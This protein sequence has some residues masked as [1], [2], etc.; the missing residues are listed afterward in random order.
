VRPFDPVR[1]VDGLVPGGAVGGNLGGMSATGLMPTTPVNPEAVATGRTSAPGPTT[2]RIWQELARASFAVLSHVTPRGEPRC[3]GVVYAIA[4]RRMFVAVAHDGWKARHIAA[5]GRVAVTVPVRRGGIMSL[6]VPIPPATI[7][8][9]G[10]AVVH[11]TGSPG[12]E[13][14]M[15]ALAH[16][17]PPERRRTSRI[18]EIRPEGWFLT[19]GVAVSLTRMRNPALARAHVP[20]G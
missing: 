20:V 19:Y 18:I 14:A 4:D 17:L 10:S 3:S 8:F 12:G 7:S 13:A 9:H 15:K 2:D 6:L 11:P 1:G 5:D 16:L